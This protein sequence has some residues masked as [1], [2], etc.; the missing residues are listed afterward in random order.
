MQGASA[1]RSGVS[2]LGR[3]RQLLQGQA[4]DA[5]SGWLWWGMQRIHWWMDPVLQIQRQP[6]AAS[7]KGAAGSV[8]KCQLAGSAVLVQACMCVK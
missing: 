3:L 7:A 4:G 8:G 1:C 5:G 2:G 6:G